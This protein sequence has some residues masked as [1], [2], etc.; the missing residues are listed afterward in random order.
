[1]CVDKDTWS[2]H[3]IPNH[4]VEQG[5]KENLPYATARLRMLVSNYDT[6]LYCTVI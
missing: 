5:N 6:Y 1:M 4:T 3:W 2:V